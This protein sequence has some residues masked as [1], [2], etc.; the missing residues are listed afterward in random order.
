MDKELALFAIKRIGINLV[1]AA[2]LAVVLTLAFLGYHQLRTWINPQYCDEMCGFRD[3][4]IVAF[5]Y[6]YI[7]CPLLG[8]KVLVEI[9]RKYRLERSAITK[10]EHLNRL[11]E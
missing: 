9:L 7:L 5:V 8:L 1:I 4:M 10:A 11:V 6:L 3:A 2:L